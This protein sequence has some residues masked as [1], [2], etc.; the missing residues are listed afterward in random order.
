MTQTTTIDVIQLIGLS[1]DIAQLNLGYLG[2]SV[3]ILGVLGGVFIYFNIKP[4]KDALDKQEASINILKKETEALLEK[5]KEQSDETLENFKKDQTSALSILLDK[6]LEKMKLEM[7]NEIV[8]TEKSISEKIDEISEGKDAKLKELIL[9]EMTNRVSVLEKS[10]LTEIKKS[11]ESIEVKIETTDTGIRRLKSSVKDLN[12]D[13]KELKVYRYAQEG[14]MG[15][16]I[17]SIEL[18]KEDI[19]EKDMNDWRIPGRLENL[20]TN[21]K[22]ISLDPEYITQI[23]EQLVRIDGEKKYSV[24]I[25]EVRDQYSQKK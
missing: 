13:I 4:L 1:R 8:E 21:I 24:L 17:Y 11:K 6:R 15:A 7:K 10:L 23:E 25:K 3:A 5:S 14:K 18:L 22:G 19:D 12:R 20:K 2:I 16:I 9:S